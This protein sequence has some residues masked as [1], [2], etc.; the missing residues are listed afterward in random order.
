MLEGLMKKISRWNVCSLVYFQ[1]PRVWAGIL[2]KFEIVHALHLLSQITN[3]LKQV[4]APD[5]TIQRKKTLSM[6]QC[7]ISY[8]IFV[9]KGASFGHIIRY[10]FKL[11]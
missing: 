2:K 8:H 3:D 9:W 6:V 1:E 10:P 7:A 4:M 5:F 11:P